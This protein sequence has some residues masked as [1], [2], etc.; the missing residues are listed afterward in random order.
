MAAL[1]NGRGRV[2]LLRTI[3]VKK[4]VGFDVTDFLLDG[5]KKDEIQG[6]VVQDPRQMDYMSM[7]AAVAA[8]RGAPIKEPLILTEA[9][10][11]TRENMQKPEIQAL[12]VP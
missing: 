1:L 9:V 6:L 8:A 3:A 2:A 12:L 10:M 7:K 11:V 5:L 4:F